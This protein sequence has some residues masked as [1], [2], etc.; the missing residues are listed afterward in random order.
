M[1]QVSLATEPPRRGFG[2]VRRDQW[3]RLGTTLVRRARASATIG[4]MDA[5]RV[6]IVTGGSRGIGRATVRTLAVRG[7]SVAV[8]YLHDQRAAE[9]VVEGVLATGGAAVSVRADVADELDV[10]RLFAET[11]AAFGGVDAVVH[12]VVGRIAVAS[13]AE[14]DVVEFDA[15]CRINTRAPLIVNREAARRIRDGGAIVN[16]F[17]SA[18]AGYG[19]YTA[20]TAATDA[21]TR[22]LAS[23]LGCRDVAVNAVAVLVD[24]LCAPRRIADAVAALLGE[25]GHGRTGQVLR[26]DGLGAFG[27]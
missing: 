27:R 16:L 9:S 4:D 23:E 21:L 1:P 2:P 5:G 3:L 25:E 20:S 19:A 14:V 10:E 12:A 7:Y 26:S 8:N 17:G 24:R 22:A 15:L 13:V 11:V 6:A 18:I